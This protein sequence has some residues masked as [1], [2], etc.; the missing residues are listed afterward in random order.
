MQNPGLPC[1]L[2]QYEPPGTGTYSMESVA[3]NGICKLAVGRRAGVERGVGLGGGRKGEEGAR[4]GGVGLERRS[5]K[6]L[7][8]LEGRTR[9]QPGRISPRGV[10]AWGPT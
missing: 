1:R 2:L 3:K 9:T 8:L 7:D 5:W 10:Q 6:Q 4:K